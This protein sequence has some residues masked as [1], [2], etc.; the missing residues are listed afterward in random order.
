MEARIKKEEKVYI[1]PQATEE[2]TVQYEQKPEISPEYQSLL[3]LHELLTEVDPENVPLISQLE[4]WKFKHKGLYISK[5]SNEDSKYYLW[6]TLK[7][8]EFKQLSQG[9]AFDTEESANEMLVEKCL[10]Y[11]SCDTLFRL[12]SDA[13]VITTLGKQISYKSGFVTPQEALALIKVV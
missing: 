5:I 2:D 10:L 1:P 12:L 6:R 8:Q 11:P 7:R 4:A 9:S 3:D 13:G